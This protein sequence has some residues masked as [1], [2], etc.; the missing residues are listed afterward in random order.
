MFRGHQR[1]KGQKTLQTQLQLLVW[2]VQACLVWGA[3]ACQQ[4]S[5]EE[6]MVEVE[7]LLGEEAAAFLLVL[8]L[9]RVVRY[10]PGQYLGWKPMLAPLLGCPASYRAVKIP[11][12]RQTDNATLR[13]T[14]PALTCHSTPPALSTL[15]GYPRADLA[16]KEHLN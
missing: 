2:Q 12:D 11:M 8:H 13:S 5:L 7:E 6:L 16:D 15:P 14:C 3:H 9:M 4:D 10:H 1:R